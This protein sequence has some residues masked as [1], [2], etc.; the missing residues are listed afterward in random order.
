MARSEYFIGTAR[1]FFRRERSIADSDRADQ[2]MH[3]TGVPR[4]ASRF[5]PC[6]RMMELKL[7]LCGCRVAL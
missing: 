5:L 3:N 4:L 6:S 1:N 2:I 7:I